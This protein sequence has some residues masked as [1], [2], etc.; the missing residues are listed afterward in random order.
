MQNN[1]FLDSACVGLVDFIGGDMRQE[2]PMRNKSRSLLL[3]V[4]TF[5]MME[6]LH[7]KRLIFAF[8]INGCN[9]TS[10][11]IL[12]IIIES[13]HINVD[14]IGPELFFVQ[15]LGCW[16][17]WHHQKTGKDGCASQ[18]FPDVPKQVKGY[19]RCFD[20]WQA[21]YIIGKMLAS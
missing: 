11:K 4:L 16:V 7:S 1:V 12:L 6:M 19:Q 3:D 17:L 21:T 2:S 13:I 20:Q 5:A 15:F 9:D 18:N 14:L 10:Q 8:V